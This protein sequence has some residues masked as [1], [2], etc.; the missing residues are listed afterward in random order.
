MECPYCGSPYIEEHEYGGWKCLECGAQF[1]DPGGG[2]DTPH[3]HS[4]YFSY[5]VS[6]TILSET[7]ATCT[8]GGSVTKQ[9][10]DRYNCSCGDYE[11]RYDTYT[12]NTSPLGHNFTYTSTVAPGLTTGGYDIYTCSRCYVT[13]QRNLTEATGAPS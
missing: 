3:Y 10:K 9:D 2:G 5:T 4:Y 8:T 1:D 6:T 13:E 11:Y 7:P 12:T